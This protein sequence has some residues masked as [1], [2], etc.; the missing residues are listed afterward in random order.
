MVNLSTLNSRLSEQSLIN[1]LAYKL[2]L[3]HH[4]V[5]FGSHIYKLASLVKD[6]WR[7]SGENNTIFGACSLHDLFHLC[8]FRQ[9]KRG[10]YNAIP[11]QTA[12]AE[13][14]GGAAAAG[15]DDPSAVYINSAALSFIDGNQ[16][17][18]GLTYVNTISSVKN[19]GATSKNLHDDDFLPNFFGNYHIPDSTTLGIGS[20]APF[21]FATSYQPDSFTRYAAIRSELRTIFVTPSISWEP[22]PYLSVGGGVSFVHS[23]AMLSRALFFGPFG[24]GKIRITDAANGYAYNL[25]LLV[26]PNHQLRFGLSY[27]SKVSLNFD[28]ADVV[29]G[30]ASGAGGCGDPHEGERDQHS[31]STD[32]QL[33]CPLA[34]ER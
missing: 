13:S 24:D 32:D 10:G 9:G 33:W 28:S 23:S 11:P 7:I 6:D 1:F 21:G 25:G 8:L 3:W 16:A 17:M 22:L 29:F 18:A 26:R 2:S 20:Y 4:L 19:S 34:S 30:D 14:M 5:T 15:V 27:K 31:T 12:K